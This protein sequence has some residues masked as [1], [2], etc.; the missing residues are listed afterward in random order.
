MY[1]PLDSSKH[2]YNNFEEKFD[3]VLTTTAIE[4]KEILLLGDINCD[5]LKTSD[6]KRIKEI[7]KRNCLKQVLKSPTRITNSTK[8]LIDIIT[9][10]REDRIENH[11]V[12]GNSISDYDLTGINRKMNC[13][14]F[15]PR[16][17]K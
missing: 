11:I 4:H 8:T 14:K 1:R 5:F 12:V 6:H 10:T 13:K 2:L 9:T 17:I 3:N 7:L 15:K 16:R